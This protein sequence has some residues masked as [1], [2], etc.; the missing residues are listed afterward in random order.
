MV[1]WRERAGLTGFCNAFRVR[2]K[3]YS[4]DAVFPGRSNHNAAVPTAHI[5]KHICWPYIGKVQH[6]WNNFVRRRHIFPKI[7]AVQ[8][9]VLGLVRDPAQSPNCKREQQGQ[10]IPQAPPNLASKHKIMH[11]PQSSTGLSPNTIECFPGQFGCCFVSLNP[12]FDRAWQR[13]IRQMMSHVKPEKEHRLAIQIPGLLKN[14]IPVQRWMTP[15]QP[16]DITH[17]IQPLPGPIGADQAQE[18][19]PIVIRQAQAR[20]FVKHNSVEPFPKPRQ[21]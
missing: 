4:P 7:S 8:K 2:V 15:D 10:P 11:R 6:F 1:I 3:S 16:G 13:H 9:S 17:E 5:I 12:I 19:K 18:Q 20:F 14:P 21:V